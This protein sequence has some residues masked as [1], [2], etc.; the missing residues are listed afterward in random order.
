[1]I[2][3]LNLKFTK[4]IF[5]QKSLIKILN[6]KMESSNK[7][8]LQATEHAIKTSAKIGGKFVQST[9][10]E[11]LQTRN[12]IWDELYSKQE[13]F[14]KNLPREKIIITL[15]NGKEV[16]GTSFE[17]TPLSIAKANLKRSLIPD[18]IAAKVNKKIL[19]FLFNFVK[20]FNFFYLLGKIFQKN[21]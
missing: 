9:T 19:F 4:K 20:N 17:T 10:P 3:W 6:F 21:H 18:F 7:R 11:F 15:K 12:K 14:L 5:N 16:E 1:M 2:R 13:D 8:I